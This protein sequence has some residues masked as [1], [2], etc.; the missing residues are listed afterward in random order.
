MKTYQRVK[1]PFKI[2]DETC[3][4][5]DSFN[6]KAAYKLNETSTELWNL[7][8]NP[9]NFDQIVDHF[10]TEFDYDEETDLVKDLEEI[11]LDLKNQSLIYEI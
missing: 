10:Q 11:L 2:I 1:I 6:N 4:I 5:I 8:E 7:L 9:H 3:Y